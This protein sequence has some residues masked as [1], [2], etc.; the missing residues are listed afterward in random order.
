MKK[1]IIS[2][3]LFLFMQV[4]VEE[5]V[6]AQT[7]GYLSYQK[8]LQSHSR[9][10]EAQKTLSQ[11][12]S[13]Y[14][15]EMSRAEQYFSKQYEEYLEGQKSFTENILMKRQKELQQLMQQS[16]DFKKE[17][18]QSLRNKETELLDPIRQQIEVAINALGTKRNL[19]YIINTDEKTH[20]FIN[21]EHGVDLTDAVLE[22]LKKE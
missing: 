19:D 18:E 7:F 2:L 12:R 14:E 8:I 13:E 21:K 1:L 10:V 3:F 22:Y 15:K 20:L 9:Y 17:A 5:N 16:M 11:L 4:I 6:T